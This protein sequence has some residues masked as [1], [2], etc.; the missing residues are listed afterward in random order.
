MLF[1]FDTEKPQSFWMKNTHIPLD[2][3]FYDKNRLP[4]DTARNMRPVS[5]TNIPMMYT[6]KPAQYVIEVLS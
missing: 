3:Y 6:S 5:E 2:I 4:V 1:I